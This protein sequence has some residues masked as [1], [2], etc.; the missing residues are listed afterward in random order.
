MQILKKAWPIYI[1][2]IHI[3]MFAVL[4]KS[5]FIE[6]AAERLGFTQQS[7]L[8]EFYH[9]MTSYHKRM[10]ASVPA[11]ATIF[12][13]DSITQSLASSAVSPVSVNYGIGGDTTLGVIN[14]LPIYESI[15]RARAVVIAIGVNDL[16]LRSN[17]LIVE[18]VRT[19]LESIPAGRA[20]VL[21]AVLPLDESIS[22]IKA[23]NSRIV[24]L[25]AALA[26]LSEEFDNV[27]FLD[28]RSDLEDASG[29]LRDHFHTGDGVHLSAAGYELW[30]AQLRQILTGV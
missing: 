21:N 1:L 3:L 13:G 6:K 10:D 8:S 20:I 5:N 2:L 22:A 7:E 9:L 23:S 15:N 29:N 12:I 27:I 17:L 25:N 28:M 18:N 14:R 16:P 30:I 19:I 11:G 4:W 26:K 24:S